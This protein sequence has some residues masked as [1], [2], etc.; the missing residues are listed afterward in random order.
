MRNSH[1]HSW[2]NGWFAQP[3]NF[4]RNCQTASQRRSSACCLP[5][6][7]SFL[8]A[9]LSGQML[10]FDGIWHTEVFV[11]SSQESL[12]FHCTGQMADSMYAWVWVSHLLLSL[13]EQSAPWRC[14]VMVW[15]DTGYRH[16]TQ[17]HFIDD[18]LNAQTCGDILRPVVMPFIQHHCL[19]VKS[20]VKGSIHDWFK[21]STQSFLW[22]G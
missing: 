6:Q 7:G 16:W 21:G 20:I 18:N 10:T 8:M 2:C 14:Y 5:S 1:P 15:A 9:D 13:R 12:S 11:S 19:K 17:V 3:N 4:C 22:R